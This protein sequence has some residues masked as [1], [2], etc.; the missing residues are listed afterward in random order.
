[1]KPLSGLTRHLI[2]H[3]SPVTSADDIV[4]LQAA[5]TTA[6]SDAEKQRLKTRLEQAVGRAANEANIRNNKAR[7]G[8]EELQ[9]RFGWNAVLT[10]SWD[11]REENGKG[12]YWIDVFV[13]PADGGEPLCFT[14]YLDVFPSDECIAN[15]ALV[16]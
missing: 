16:T 4:Q 8:K 7:R 2:T 14:E 9:R 5:L 15:I 10:A 6:K 11:W 1:M 3:P 12:E 13:Q